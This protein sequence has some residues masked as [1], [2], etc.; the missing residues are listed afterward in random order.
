MGNLAMDAHQVSRRV[1][2]EPCHAIISLPIDADA[3]RRGEV[4]P[5]AVRQHVA[6]DVIYA[7]AGGRY[8]RE[9]AT[10]ALA[11]RGTS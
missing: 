3:Q 2:S 11:Q 6:E 4:K 10:L 8:A 7:T 1:Q 5:V 9:V